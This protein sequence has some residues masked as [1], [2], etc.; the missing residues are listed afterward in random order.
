MNWKQDEE[1]EDRKKKKKKK[2]KKKLARLIDR[3]F[4][5]NTKPILS[6]SKY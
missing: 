5:E 1:D 4:V 3:L 2:K 6:L